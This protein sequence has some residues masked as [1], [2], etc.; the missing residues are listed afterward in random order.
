LW[1][2][3]LVVGENANW[4]RFNASLKLEPTL[5]WLLEYNSDNIGIKIPY[6]GTRFEIGLYLGREAPFKTNQ[7]KSLCRP[8]ISL[9]ALYFIYLGVDHE[10]E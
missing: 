4:R 1:I 5:K 10:D 7:N 8:E 9:L 3:W 6:E 2:K